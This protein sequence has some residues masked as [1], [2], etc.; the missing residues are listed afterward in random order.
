MLLLADLDPERS[1]VSFRRL[2]G[3]FVY[4]SRLAQSGD[5]ASLVIGVEVRVNRGCS[6]E[7]LLLSGEPG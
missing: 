7:E 6:R 3:C 4:A 2:A 5:V 1:D